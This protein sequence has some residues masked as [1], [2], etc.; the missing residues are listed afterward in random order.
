MKISELTEG[1]L[2]LAR[3]TYQHY[4]LIVIEKL[5]NEE[6]MYLCDVVSNW[7]TKPDTYDFDYLMD[8][9]DISLK[10]KLKRL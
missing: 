3:N 4:N 2:L 6:N 7:E 10:S 8:L 9:Y 1:D 5:D